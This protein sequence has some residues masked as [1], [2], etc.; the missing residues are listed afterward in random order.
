MSP[1]QT[2]KSKALT[3]SIPTPGKGPNNVPLFIGAVDAPARIKG[4]VNFNCNYDCKGNDIYINYIAVAEAK[5]SRRSGNRTYTYRGRQVFNEQNLRMALPHPSTGTVQ[6]GQY[7]YS[8]DFPVD[9]KTTPSSFKGLY[10]WMTYRVRVTL[11]RSFPSLNVVR[12]QTV[13]VLNSLIPRPER[14]LADTPVSMTQFSGVLMKTV[15]YI[16]VIPSVLLYLGQQVPVTIKVQA[17]SSPIFVQSAVIKLK[18]YSTLRVRSGTK[19]GKK[20]LLNVP[21]DGGWPQAE[22]HKAWQ[23]TVIV[24]LPG[25]PQLTPTVASTMI[26]KVHKLKLIMQVRMGQHGQREELR[27]EMPVVITGPR[28]PGEPYPSFDMPRYLASVNTI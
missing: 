17:A 19:T 18:Q 26:T 3:L 4:M 13:W 7:A 20:E 22:V 11:V 28:P 5:W 15:P 8:F 12:E 25:A 1:T 6:A 27:I 23:R 9:A 14:P 24:T 16:C 10:S 21:L 2:G